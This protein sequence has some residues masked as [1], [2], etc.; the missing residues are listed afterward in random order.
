MNKKLKIL[1]AMKVVYIKTYGCQMNIY[2]SNRIAEIFTSLGYKI[3]ATPASADV[4]VFNGCNVRAKAFEKVFSDIGQIRSANKRKG[5]KAIV[6]L[7]GCVGQAAGKDAFKRGVDIVVGPRSYHN[8]PKL[9]EEFEMQR[10]FASNLIIADN[11]KFTSLPSRTLETNYSAFLTIQEGCNK[12]CKYCSVPYTRGREFS[13][14]FDEVVTEAKQLVANGARELIL[15]GQNVNAYKSEDGA[16]KLLRLANLIFEISKINGAKRIRYMTSHP[17]DMYQGLIKAHGEIE[18]LMPHVHLPVQ[19]GSDKVL[20]AMNRYHTVDQYLKIVSGLRRVRPDLC[21]S[22]DIIVG[23]PTETDEDFEATMNLIKQVRFAQIYSFKY[24]PR[25][26][27][28][29]A[30]LPQLPEKIKDFRL[31]AL[32]ALANLQQKE[33]NDSFLDKPLEVLL[34]KKGKHKNQAVGFSQYMQPVA[35]SDACNLLGQIVTV[36]VEKILAHTLV[37]F[38]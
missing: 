2:D 26:G 4:L 36:Q 15:L 18:Q 16:G 11:E 1:A 35:V 33:F 32:Q 28:E 29:A 21:L 9:L 22:T 5:K 14:P 17:I 25:K 3:G 12:F 10:K 38:L 13:R 31:Q 7:A 8:L 20:K 30:E 24:S 34:T 27:T 6:V 19:S 37:G 23:Y